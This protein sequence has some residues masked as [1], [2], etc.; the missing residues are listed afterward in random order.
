MNR[1]I[2]AV[3][4]ADAAARD[5]LVRMCE[6]M[7]RFRAACERERRRA[8]GSMIP[9]DDLIQDGWSGCSKVRPATA[10]AARCATRSPI[11]RH[12]S[13]RR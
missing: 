11:S 6:P 4:D 3:Q 12:G 9:L 2:A 10:P 8:W 5:E 13:C 7:V 1:V